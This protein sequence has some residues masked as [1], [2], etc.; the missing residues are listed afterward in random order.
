V[1]PW[2]KTV[3]D[4]RPRVLTGFA[5]TSLYRAKRPYYEAEFDEFVKN[6]GIRTM[7]FFE[8]WAD[9][10]SYISTPPEKA[11]KLKSLI[12]AAQARGVQALLYFGGFISGIAPE[13]D[14]MWDECLHLPEAGWDETQILEQ[15]KQKLKAVCYESVWQDL[16]ADGIARAMDEYG[17]DGVYLDGVG[18]VGSCFN[19]YHG[20]G[21]VAQDGSVRPTNHLLATRKLFERIYKIVK[22][23]KPEGQIK[24]HQSGQ[25]VAPVLGFATSY[26][27][28]EQFG[29][30]KDRFLLDALPLDTFRTEFMGRQWGV[31]AEMLQYRLPGTHHQQLGLFLLHDVTD[32]GDLPG[33]RKLWRLADEFGHGDAEWLPYWANSEFV[34]VLPEVGKVS[35]YRHQSNGVLIMVLNTGREEA[36]VTV[37][38]NMDVFEGLAKATA[39]DGITGE[40]MAVT[41]GGL[42]LKL[43]SL[44]WKLIWIKP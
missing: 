42:S 8:T 5:K 10:H 43:K 20:C 44:D 18:D 28:G 21:Y 14:V 24:L 40:N 27:D 23:R 26:W 4:Y 30:S 29:G 1:K 36:D 25:M 3:W 35:L 13:A 39:V 11:E 19:L 12:K 16:V 6:E 7:V 33:N 15:P 38:L 17:I 32:E 41:G 9:A 22:S 31:P 2:G 37:Q 34:T